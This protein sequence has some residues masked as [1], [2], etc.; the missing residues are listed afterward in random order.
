MMRIW[1]EHP[2]VQG[3]YGKQGKTTPSVNEAK[4]SQKKDNIT[5]SS[6]ARDYQ[7]VMKKLKDVPDVRAEKVNEIL[8][9]INSGTYDVSGRDVADKIIRSVF[10]KKV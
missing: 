9:K 5:I 10:D 2:K 1:G 4:A 3:T 7:I 8:N 6:F